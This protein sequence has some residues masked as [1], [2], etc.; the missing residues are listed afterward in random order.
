[1]INGLMLVSPAITFQPLCFDPGNDLPYQAFLPSYAAT[2]WYH[3]RLPHKPADL[4]DFLA[5][6]RRFAED[7]YG[8]ALMRGAR[9]T[10]AEAAR[11]AEALH[12]YTGLPV[13]DLLAADLR[14]TDARFTKAVLREPGRPSAGS[15]AGFADPTPARTATPASAIPATTAPWAPTPASSTCMS[16]G[17][18]GSIRP[19]RTWCSAPRPTRSGAGTRS[20]RS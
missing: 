1:M 10:D 9:I 16:A 2:A 5:E 8:P 17:R 3:D 14:I 13:A 20:P 11:V 19:S 4:H 15:T 18:S 12:R 7:V 6:V